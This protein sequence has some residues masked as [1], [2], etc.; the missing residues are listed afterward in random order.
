MNAYCALFLIKGW[1]LV[2]LSSSLSQNEGRAAQNSHF[3]TYIVYMTVELI[4]NKQKQTN[5]QTT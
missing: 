3:V 4:K 1:Y 5:K 2:P